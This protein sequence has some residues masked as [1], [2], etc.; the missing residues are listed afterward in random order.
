VREAVAGG[1]LGEV[2]LLDADVHAYGWHHAL[3]LLVFLLGVPDAVEATV[4]DDPAV[5]EFHWEDAD[6]LLYIPTDAVAA[7]FRYDDG[8]T[9]SVTATLHT[10]LGE[11][12]I[13]LSV[14]GRDGEVR[15]DGTTPADST[16][17]VRPGPLADRL[18]AVESV[19][20]EAA[21][22]RSVAAFADARRRG[23][24]PPTTGVDG[25]RAMLLEDA[26]VR[27]GRTE[28]AVEVRRP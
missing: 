26:V 28:G 22:A 11:H 4:R 2:T 16:G 14:Y 15:I 24:A 18:R 13:D 25:L 8:P 27:A 12:L 21:F 17:D 10:D 6:E 9:A 20:L 3:D 1:E 5:R 7:T 23:E 19:T